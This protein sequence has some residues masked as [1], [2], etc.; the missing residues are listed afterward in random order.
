MAKRTKKKTTKKTT[1]SESICKELELRVVHLKA[2]NSRLST[3]IDD[4]TAELRSSEHKISQLE[5][6]VKQTTI[7]HRYGGYN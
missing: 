5:E 6:A 1:V 4:L 3:T 7:S 2:D